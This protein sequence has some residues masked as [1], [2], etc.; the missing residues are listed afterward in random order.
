M[1]FNAS[2]KIVLVIGSL[3]GIGKEILKS[4]AKKGATVITEPYA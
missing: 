2:E 1:N 4:F 3:R